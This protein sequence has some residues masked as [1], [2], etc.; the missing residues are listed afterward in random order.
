MEQLTSIQLSEWEA[1]DRLD[2]VGTWRDDFRIATLS[3]LI[4]NIVRTLYPSE[5]DRK[6]GV[7]PTLSAPIDFMVDWGEEKEKPEPK[8]QTTEEMKQIFYGLQRVQKKSKER[9]RPPKKRKK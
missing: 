3:S 2:P 4:V 6:K 1:Y 7:E 9:T 5:E 8:K